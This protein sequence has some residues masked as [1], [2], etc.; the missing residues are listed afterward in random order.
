MDLE[1]TGR[2]TQVSPQLRKQAEAGL[3]RIERILG[4]KSTAKVVLTCEKY[5]CQVE[6]AV[7]NPLHD[8][9]AKTE[10]KVA[11]HQE[12]AEL[13][14][15][16]AQALNKVET[17]ALKLKKRMITKQ[18]HP[19]QDGTGSVRLQ[20]EDDDAPVNEID[21]ESKRLAQAKTGI[22]KDLAL[23]DDGDLHDEQTVAA[24]R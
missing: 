21:P 17:Q 8:L 19:E 12:A 18:H 1:I 4:P 5:Q 9:S 14:A 22:G 20:S 24:T 7:F 10:A 2:G 15:A 23:M 11:M 3:E 16:L 13:E 6:V